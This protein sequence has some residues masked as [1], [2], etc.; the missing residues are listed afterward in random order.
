M[1]KYFF[2]N[3]DAYTTY[4]VVF[5][6]GTFAELLSIPGAWPDETRKLGLPILIEGKNDS[7]F[8]VK[9]NAFRTFIT[10]SE[11]FTFL[12]DGLYRRFKLSYESMSAF[13]MLTNITG[14]NKVYCDFVLNLIDDYPD[15]KMFTRTG[16][17]QKNNSPIG[18]VGGTVQ[19]SRT[20]SSFTLADATVLGNADTT[21]NAGGQAYANANGTNIP[22][23]DHFISLVLADSGTVDK[24]L[25]ETLYYG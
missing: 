14:G 8:W 18:Y 10:T 3:L 11:D 16:S 20:Y 21:F 12:V 23:L 5:K 24:Q 9:Y 25:L 13:K 1:G 6:K 17:F 2:N 4:G 19:F 22:V 7:D 15:V